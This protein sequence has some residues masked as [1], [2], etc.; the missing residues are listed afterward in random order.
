MQTV[1]RKQEMQIFIKM[2]TFFLTVCPIIFKI[3]GV[4]AI[5]EMNK[6]CKFHKNPTKNVNF[7]A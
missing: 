4:Q 1:S 2:A 6:L 3:N 7:I 5:G